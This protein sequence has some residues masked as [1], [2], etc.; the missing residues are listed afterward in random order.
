MQNHEN[1]SVRKKTDQVQSSLYQTIF[2]TLFILI[3]KKDL[4]FYRSIYIAFILMSKTNCDAKIPISNTFQLIN[5]NAFIA[6]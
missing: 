1:H 4:C 3:R 2:M 5:F 6:V